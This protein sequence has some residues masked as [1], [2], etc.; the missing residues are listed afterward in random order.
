MPN[1]TSDTGFFGVYVCTFVLRADAIL[2]IG[3]AFFVTKLSIEPLS[4]EPRCFFAAGGGVS[5]ALCSSAAAPALL[6]PAPLGIGDASS[7]SS[8]ASS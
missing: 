7:S 2:A 5:S 8:S 6:G 1:R 3:G 4:I